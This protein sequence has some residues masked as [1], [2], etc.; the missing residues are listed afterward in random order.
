MIVDLSKLP[1]N[2]GETENSACSNPSEESGS[3]RPSS[4]CSLS[5]FCCPAFIVR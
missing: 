4:P 2:P 3:A 5:F 1:A